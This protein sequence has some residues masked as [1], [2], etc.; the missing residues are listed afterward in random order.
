LFSQQKYSES[1]GYY[2]L[3]AYL[4]PSE[5]SAWNNLGNNYLMLKDLIKAFECFQKV[6]ALDKNDF[7]C[8]VNI[9]NCYVTWNQPDLAV[10]YYLK[11][12]IVDMK[13]IVPFKCL[14]GIYK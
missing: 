2:E 1:L 6:I 7:N 8:L 10:L 3:E 4:A 11:A 9:G 5:P 13:S 14:A 12:A